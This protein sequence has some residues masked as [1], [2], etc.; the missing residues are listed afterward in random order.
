MFLNCGDFRKMVA[1]NLISIGGH[2]FSHVRL[3]HKE[4]HVISEILRGIKG[5]EVTGGMML[6]SHEG[7]FVEMSHPVLLK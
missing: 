3:C 2:I 7:L 4:D 5:L 1:S 6:T